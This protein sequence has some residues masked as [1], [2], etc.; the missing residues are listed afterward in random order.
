MEKLE[1]SKLLQKQF[2]KRKNFFLLKDIEESK[3]AA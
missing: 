1:E 2:Q 3:L